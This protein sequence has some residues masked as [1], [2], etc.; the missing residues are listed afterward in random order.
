MRMNKKITD[1]S[2]PVPIS[3]NPYQLLLYRSLRDYDVELYPKKIFLYKDLVKFRGKI[4]I[5]H[6]HWLFNQTQSLKRLIKFLILLFEAKILGYGIVRNIHNIEHHEYKTICDWIE[7]FFLAHLSN[8]LIVH[9]ES[10]RNDVE[11][12]YRIR[13]KICV[14]PYGNYIEFYPNTIERNEARKRL[15]IDA[16][17]ICLSILWSHKAI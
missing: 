8:A 12:I 17:F 6:F 15:C 1:Y 16:G 9:G 4:D 13:D 14:I 11:K 3:E 7:R 5:I 2:F 10:V